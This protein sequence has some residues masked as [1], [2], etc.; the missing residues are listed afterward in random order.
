[1]M[2]K[3][4]ALGGAALLLGSLCTAQAAQA[5]PQPQPPAAAEASAPAAGGKCY[6]VG[7]LVKNFL[8]LKS[9]GTK[10]AR[11]DLRSMMLRLLKDPSKKA[12]IE[13]V[14][15]EADKAGY[16]NDMDY[17]KAVFNGVKAQCKELAPLAKML[18]K[19]A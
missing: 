13:R 11:A 3:R 8:A 1:M 15:D 14:F 7:E 6:N 9:S 10:D 5:E 12:A 19:G 2:M 16:A 17:A 18:G 4:A